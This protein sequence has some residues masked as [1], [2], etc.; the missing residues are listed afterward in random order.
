MQALSGAAQMAH[1]VTQR[2]IGEILRAAA[3]RSPEE[4]PT[5]FYGMPFIDDA[6]SMKK[7][8]RDVESFDKDFG[9]IGALGANRI[10]VPQAHW[11]PRWQLTQ[12][13]LSRAGHKDR[14]AAVRAAY[15]EALDRV[16]TPDPKRIYAAA[17]E[18]AVDIFWQALGE[19]P[20]PAR[21]R[22]AETAHLNEM[23]EVTR[24]LQAL[25]WL[26]DARRWNDAVAEEC[27]TLRQ[28]SLAI[29]ESQAPFRKALEALQS[30]GE[31]KIEGFNAVEELQMNLAAGTETS[32]SGFL[33]GL[34]RLAQFPETQERLYR[35]QQKTGPEAQAPLLTAFCQELLRLHAPI[36]FVSRKIVK[37]AEIG[38]RTWQPGGMAIFSI[39][40]LHRKKAAWHEPLRF[41]PERRAF[42]E[43]SY[44]RFDFLPFITGPRVCGGAALAQME[45]E[46][47][48]AAIVSRYRLSISGEA[49]GL[50]YA[51]TWRPANPGAVAFALRR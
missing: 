31:K 24:V 4:A 50:D 46:Q 47:G 25:G 44:D 35:E 32:I 48:L 19:T 10:V 12:R 3:A 8:L 40:G 33:W 34:F 21:D 9:F 51:V 1:Q 23:R 38:G 2:I 37:P 18:A 36:P 5:A 13:A 17:H 7:L 41:D 16:E 39:L 26:P 43:G 22:A 42:L 49:P 27:G 45:L 14:T 15:E 6:A 30:D 20:D 29:F 28:K 11:K